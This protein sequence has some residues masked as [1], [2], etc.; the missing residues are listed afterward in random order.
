VARDSMKFKRLH[1]KRTAVE[2]VNGRLDCDYGFE[3]NIRGLNKMSLY[4]TTSFFMMMA[5]KKQNSI[6]VI[7]VK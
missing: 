2:R 1:N 5:R 7:K 3:F 4:V 6:G